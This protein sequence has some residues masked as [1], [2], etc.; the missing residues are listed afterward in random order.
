M[1][2]HGGREANGQ[3]RAPVD[4]RRRYTPADGVPNYFQ[5]ATQ[6]PAARQEPSRD[7]QFIPRYLEDAA[8]GAAAGQERPVNEQFTWENHD[9]NTVTAV[10]PRFSTH[11]TSAHT[12][13]RLIDYYPPTYDQQLSI[14]GAVRDP[15]V[16]EAGQ[17]ELS[18]REA[19]HF[20]AQQAEYRAEQTVQR[21]DQRLAHGFRHIAPVEDQHVS[22]TEQTRL[23][24]LNLEL[25]DARHHHGRTQA[26]TRLTQSS[27]NDSHRRSQQRIQAERDQQPSFV[28]TASSPGASH[29][30]THRSRNPTS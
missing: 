30:P 26:R 3:G 5:H 4:T 7:E 11:E 15:N 9:L 13:G 18:Q 17:L 6:A 22:E 24:H 12:Y 28:I 2:R 20:E 16:S 25:E 27:L 21:L 19:E 29:Y 1:S 14:I 10:N 23:R 8:Q